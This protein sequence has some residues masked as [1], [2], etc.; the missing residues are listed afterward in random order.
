M[1][2]RAALLGGLAVAVSGA[3]EMSPVDAALEINRTRGKKTMLYFGT[4]SG[5]NDPGIYL[6]EMDSDSEKLVARGSVTGLASP[7]FLT[8]HP[9]KK[10]LYAVC[11]AASPNGGQVAAYAIE[12]KTGMLTLLNKESAKGQGPCHVSMDR[13]GK[14]VVVAN[15]GDGSIACLPVGEDGKLGAATAAI[16]HTGSS[17]NQSRQEG[18]HAHSMNVD[19]SGK[20]VVAADLGTD[21]LYVYRLDTKTGTLTPNDPPSVSSKPGAGPR[22]FAFHP[23]GK[24]AFVINELDNTVTAYS[25][26]GAKGILTTLSSVTTLPSDYTGNN[27]STAEI[28]VHPSGK[29]V[30]GSNRGHNSIAIFAFDSKTGSLTPVGHESTQGKIPRNFGISPDGKF[31]IA[32]NQDSNNV[33]VFKIDSNTGKLTATGQTITIPKPVCVK[34]LPL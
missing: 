4:Y 16:Q 34:F 8:I 33:V 18:P 3:L 9:N 5:E 29:F 6:Y 32:C 23:D 25:W 7:S 15:Y 30:Y 14:V 13:S 28:Q 27:N 31:L 12:P 2:L 1:V 10:F 17:V 21:K 20:F 24:H 19:P 26:D 22:H 11:E